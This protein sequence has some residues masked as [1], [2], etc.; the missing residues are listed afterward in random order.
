MGTDDCLSIKLYT[1]FASHSRLTRKINLASTMFEQSKTGRLSHA[2]RSCANEVMILTLRLTSNTSNGVSLNRGPL[3]GLQGVY[4]NRP[5]LNGNYLSLSK[6]PPMQ[7]GS[8]SNRELLL[9]ATL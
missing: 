1:V 3:L 8:Y 2:K 7:K 4:L 6:G 9:K 5:Y